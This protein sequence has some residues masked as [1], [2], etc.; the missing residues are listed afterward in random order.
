MKTPQLDLSALPV[1]GQIGIPEDYLDEM[2]HMNVMWYIYLFGRAGEKL[3]GT[4]GMTREFM[5]KQR[6]GAFALEA[7]IHYFQEVRVRDQV[8]IRSRLIGR[9]EKRYHVMHF[10]SHEDGRLAAMGEFVGAHID[11][12]TRRMAPIPGPVAREFDRLQA[13]HTRLPWP[14]PLTGVMK[15]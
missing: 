5:E 9:T 8:A 14:A 10:M 6:A 13:E 3:F 15:P 4:F 12:T 7:H 2:G 1:T 11:M